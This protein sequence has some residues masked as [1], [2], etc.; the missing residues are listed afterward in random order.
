MTASTAGA[1]RL[2][3]FT[4]GVNLVEVYASVTDTQGNPVTGL[5]RADFELRENGEPQAIANF[6]AGDFPLSAAVAI[7]RSFSVAGTK[8]SLAKA[9]GQT[10]LA[11]LRAQDEAMII[12][13]GSQIDVIAPL[14]TDRTSQ[15][16]AVD[17]LDA[18]GTTGLHDAIIHAIDAVQPAKG[19]RALI[20]L[21]DGDDRYSR[22]TVTDVLDRARRSDVMV[23]PIALGRTRP[24]L[25]AELATLTGGRS[26]HA[27]DADTLTQ[28]MR[29]IAREL[30]WQYLLGYTPTRAPVSGSNEWRSIS[31]R[32]KRPDATVRARDGYL[33]Q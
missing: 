24:P 2:G 4:S 1:V 13:I 27:T 8:L 32:V 15:R 20:V 25:F 33:I 26:A 14:S 11:E 22:A 18:F 17:R 29:A 12:A 30:R 3:Q 16:N 28:T 21:S 5:T 19:R 10:F 31:V 7:D 6:T 9:A 23:F